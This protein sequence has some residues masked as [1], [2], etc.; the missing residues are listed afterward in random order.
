[1]ATFLSRIRCLAGRHDWVQRDDPHGYS[2]GP[3]VVYRFC[4]RCEKQKRD[5]LTPVQRPERSSG[6]LWG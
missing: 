4:R 6:D 2:G 5:D 1:M 3:L